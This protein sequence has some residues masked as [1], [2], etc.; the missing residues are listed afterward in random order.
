[1]KI[2]PSNV[3]GPSRL[4]RFLGAFTLPETQITLTIFIV[5]IGG[6]AVTYLF[7]VRLFELVR[8]RLDATDQAR[9]LLGI[10]SYEVRSAARI[11]VGSGDVTSFTEV[12][13]NTNQ[14]GSAI[15]IY[16]DSDTNVFI[17]YFW[18]SNQTVS[19]LVSKYNTNTVSTL[20]T[21]VTNS[22]IFQAED[23]AGKLLTNN[24]NNRVIAMTLHFYQPEYPG[25]SKASDFYHLH[26]RVTRR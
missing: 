24:Q 1:M 14:V 16:P 3:R 21:K 22:I 15:Q 12:G 19:R 23:Y 5:V 26:T 7:G 8:P 17:R 13:I 25:G 11:L 18:N 10:L 2:N 4:K 20:A 6:M 9:T